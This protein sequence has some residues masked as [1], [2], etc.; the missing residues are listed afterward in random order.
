MRASSAAIHN[1]QGDER[2]ALAPMVLAV[3]A[4][5]ALLRWLGHTGF[6]GSDEV[7]YIESA[8]KP[9]DGDWTLDDYV[10]A[11]R[12]G[13]N[14][15]MAAFAAVFGRN[16]F[17]LGL[18]GFLCSIGEVALVAWLGGRFFGWRAGLFAGLLLAVTPVHAHI[19]GRMLADP[20]LSLVI[21]GSFALFA[22]AE[23]RRSALGFFW[24]GVLAGT[25][26]LIKP[27]TLFVFGILLLYPLVARR[28][29]LRWLWMVA[30]LSV[31]MVVN[32]WLYESLTGRFWYVFEVVRERRQSGYLEAGASAGSIQLDAFLYFEYLFLR[33]VHTGAL[34]WLAAGGAAWL[35]IR[36]AGAAPTSGPLRFTLFW[37]LGLILILSFLPASF[38]PLMF[39]PK[40]SN[41]MLIFAAPLA[42][43]GGWLLAELPRRWAVSLA[44]GAAGLG[45]AL[46]LLLQAQLM[47]FTANSWA[48]L[49]YVKA[50]G[51]GQ[52]VYVMSNAYR[53]A[54]YRRLLG[55]EDLLPQL[56]S[57]QDVVKDS[58]DRDRLVLIDPQT[59]HWDGSRPFARLDAAPPCWQRVQ[60]LRG[61]PHGAGVIFARAVAGFVQ[62]LPVSS[63]AALAGRIRQQAVEPL[64]V[65]VYVVPA[66]CP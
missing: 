29:D 6:F 54:M 48:T 34:G 7:T 39:V 32:G 57:A 62:A 28:I 58:A 20:A 56:R 49:D 41:Y 23:Q 13:V 12:I 2:S 63:A 24:A 37:A 59:L 36:R 45:C 64:P 61:T 8:L 42:L 55:G 66:G 25:S 19:A 18:Y 3:V 14:M 10:G 26:F 27:V 38:Q 9:L 52:S 16:E 60:T 1:A 43:L 11:N 40:Q 30:G 4:V 51:D 17:G 44:I 22:L 31:M 5:A 50:R 53:A 21:T 15:P 35:L 47:T 46:T 33:V 65:Q